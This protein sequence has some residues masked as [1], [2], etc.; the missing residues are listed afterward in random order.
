MTA[1]E[2]ATLLNALHGVM[3]VHKGWDFYK[4]VTSQAN[5]VRWERGVTS[6]DLDLV[7]GVLAQNDEHSIPVWGREHLQA[8]LAELSL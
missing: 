1:D 2:R 8:L 6:T 4:I 7:R 3:A 5:H